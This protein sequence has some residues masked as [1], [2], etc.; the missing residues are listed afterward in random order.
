MSFGPNFIFKL[1]KNPPKTPKLKKVDNTYKHTHT[2][3]GQKTKQ[4]KADAT[5]V[6]LARSLGKCINRKSFILTSEKK[7]QKP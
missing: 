4:T 5:A 2:P 3:S 6:F 1:P 7:K